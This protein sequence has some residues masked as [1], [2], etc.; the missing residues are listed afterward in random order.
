MRAAMYGEMAAAV[1][2]YRPWCERERNWD[3]AFEGAV[4]FVEAAGLD[5]RTSRQLL[6]EAAATRNAGEFHGWNASVTELCE[7]LAAEFRFR[8]RHR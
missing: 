6:D 8:V 7:R 1:S 2:G 3:A 5:E 4:R